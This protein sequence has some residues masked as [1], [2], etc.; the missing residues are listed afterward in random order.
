[1]ITKQFE[2]LIK[3]SGFLILIS[4]LLLGCGGGNSSTTFTPPQDST[5]VAPTAPTITIDLPPSAKIGETI[6]VSALVNTPGGLALIESRTSGPSGNILATLSPEE[7]GCPLG[8]LS[9]TFSQDITLGFSAKPGTYSYT[10]KVTDQVGQTT[11]ADGSILI[12]L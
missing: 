7:L 11:T 4:Q 12:S 2:S 3:T 1:M 6:S 9:C 5:T 10:L 8:A